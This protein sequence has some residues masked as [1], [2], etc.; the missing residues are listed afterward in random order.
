MQW[1]VGGLFL[2]SLRKKPTNEAVCVLHFTTPMSR[3]ISWRMKSADARLA[4]SQVMSLLLLIIAICSAGCDIRKQDSTIRKLLDSE[5][6][7]G[8]QILVSSRGIFRL[9]SNKGSLIPVYDP[10]TSPSS[11][12]GMA[13]PSP[14]GNRIT[15]SESKDLQTYS[16][17]ILDLRTAQCTFP[18]QFAYLAGPSWSPRGD[19]IAFIA[20]KSNSGAASSIYLYKIASTEPLLVVDSDA[21]SVDSP[22]SWSPDGDAIVYQSVRD[23]I[24]VVDINSEAIKE[25]GSGRFPS[26]SPNG[27]YIAYQKVDGSYVVRDLQSNIDSRILVDP[28]VGRVLVWSPDSRLLVYSKIGSGLWS[29]LGNILSVSD[30]YSDLWIMDLQSQFQTRVYRHNGSLYPSA[31]AKINFTR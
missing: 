23:S 15:F 12:I 4:V 24:R 10:T 27:R 5:E 18:V 13:S 29:H 25:V 28:S 19:S 16:L 21:A 11:Y 1:A 26:W 6:E 30:S 20:A 22:L 2:P 7:R 9:D 14:D 17:V 3:P 8:N 31:W